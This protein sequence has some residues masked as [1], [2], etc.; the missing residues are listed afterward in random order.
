MSKVR[1][2]LSFQKPSDL[3]LR[4]V[5]TPRPK[6]QPK[7]LPPKA[8]SPQK[9]KRTYYQPKNTLTIGG[10]I[11]PQSIAGLCI[12]GIS[13]KHG[14]TSQKPKK[15]KS[16]YRPR[17]KRTLAGTGFVNSQSI[18][19]LCI[20]GISIRSGSTSQKSKK[21][22]SYYRPKRTL[23]NNDLTN[24]QYIAGLCI[25]GISIEHGPNSRE[26]KTKNPTKSSNE[27]TKART[28]R[29]KSPKAKG[30]SSVQEFR[31]RDG[32]KKKPPEV[33]DEKLMGQYLVTSARRG[34]RELR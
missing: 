8:I 24:S 20:T 9:A 26:L 13:V 27:S 12:T 23:A 7:P 6:A 29:R 17:P 30:S 15:R 19:G 1:Q 18:A 28:K 33:V 22:R 31:L 4:T 14:P 11:T 25:T 21:K 16:Y 5:F 10:P 34:K 32:S 2:I 3:A